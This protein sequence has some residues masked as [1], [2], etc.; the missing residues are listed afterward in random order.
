[1]TAPG[2]QICVVRLT[3][4]TGSC[5]P[6]PARLPAGSYSLTASY[7]GDYDFGPSAS[8]SQAVTVTRA[9]T[10]VT[11]AVGRPALI[12]GGE[13]PESFTARYHRNSPESHREMPPSPSATKI[14]SI[15]VC[16]MP[17]TSGTG[18]CMPFP[19]AGLPSGVYKVTASYPGDPD[20]LPSASGPATL[21][22]GRS[23]TTI[24]L[25]LVASGTLQVYSTVTR[26][27]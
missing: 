21:T 7:G 17:L 12:L 20:F 16:T 11:L 19:A 3:L 4:G 10:R 1:M 9:T 22:V 13:Q 27:S 14:G 6:A 18:S 26:P 15:R 2:S 5:A 8:A 23:G 24:A 25:K